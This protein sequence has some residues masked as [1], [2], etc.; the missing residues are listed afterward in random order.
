MQ[1]KIKIFV[2]NN[3]SKIIKIDKSIFLIKRL[4]LDVKNMRN[5]LKL[6]FS[7]FLS[8]KKY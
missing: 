4:R 1:M 7:R 5:R 6:Q 3:M 8:I 2:V